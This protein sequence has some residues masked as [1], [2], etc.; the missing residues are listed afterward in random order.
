M[1]LLS[2][3]LMLELQVSPYQF[4]TALDLASEINPVRSHHPAFKVINHTSNRGP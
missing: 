1:R 2:Y 4:Y 3:G